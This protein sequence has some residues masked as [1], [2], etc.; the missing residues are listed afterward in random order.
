MDRNQKLNMLF[1]AFAEELNITRTMFDNAERAYNALGDYIKGN[2]QDWGVKVIPQGSFALGTVVKPV[3]EGGQYDVDLVVL[4]ENPIMRADTLRSRVYEML[5][6]HGRYEGKIEDKKPCIRIQY[7]DSAQFHMDVASAQPIISDPPKL[8]LAKLDEEGIYKYDSSN[9]L[10][11]IDWFKRVMNYERVR[12]ARVKYYASTDVKEIELP[13]VRTSLQKAVQIIK[14]HRDVFCEGRDEQYVPSSIILT[15]L[16]GLTYNYQMPYAI[17]TGNVYDALNS[18]LRGF[19]NF[20]KKD[21]YGNYNLPNPSYITENF[22]KKWNDDENYEMEFSKWITQAI[23]DILVY[24]ER[25]ID[26]DQGQLRNHFEITFGKALSTES[27]S[28]Y[29]REFGKISEKREFRYDPSSQGITTD[30]SAQPYKQ[31]TYFGEQEN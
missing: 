4:V 17:D 18:M 7:A 28:R 14:R 5:E 30:P 16:C 31:H 25:Y 2:N 22:L 8:N 1:D 19:Q 11:Y 10:G 6:N 15:T 3:V 9:P 12:E 23:N 27:L 26:T 21:Q 24:P 20:I 13:Y 29:G